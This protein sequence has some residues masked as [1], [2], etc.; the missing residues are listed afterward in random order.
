MTIKQLLIKKWN[1][2]I[3]RDI[4]FRKGLNLIINEDKEDRWNNVGK[5]TV[6]R[7]I[8]YCL[9]SDGTS[10]YEDKEQKS[11]NMVVWS[12][13]S[14]NDVC[15]ELHTEWR[16]NEQFV[17]KR[18]FWNNS[19]SCIINDEVFTLTEYREQLNNIFFSN[20]SW[21]PTFRML[22]HKFIRDTDH[23]M[24]NILRFWD[25]STAD[26]E[27]ERI[28]LFL[29][30]FSDL[31][32]L[33]GK[34]SCVNDIKKLDDK[35]K[36]F[37]Q[38]TGIKSDSEL[39]Q[40][41]AIYDNKINQLTELIDKSQVYD[42]IE[43]II[44]ELK[45]ISNRAS[46]LRQNI[47]ALEIDISLNQ[48]SKTKLIKELKTIDVNYIKSIYEQAEIF[49]PKIDKTF[50]EVIEFHEKTVKNRLNLIENSID[51]HYKKLEVFKPEYHTLLTKQQELY[52]VVN[53]KDYNTE[54]DV[55]KEKLNILNQEKWWLKNNLEIFQ[56]L[57]RNLEDLKKR[58]DTIIK[59]YKESLLSVE[60]NLSIFNSY[61][62]ERSE[63]IYGIPLIVF[64]EENNSV[65]KFKTKNSL[66]ND[67]TWEKKSQIAVF[68]FAYSKF[69]DEIDAI[70]PRFILH[71]N[72]EWKDPHHLKAIF[73]LANVFGGQYIVPVLKD[74]L[75]T[76]LSDE[77][78]EKFKV[79]SLSVNDKFFR[80]ETPS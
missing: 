17:F 45:D 9:W 25:S 41:I 53:N 66:G 52:K 6:L 55:L 58:Y 15:F 19:S 2:T 16:K 24:A 26:K 75:K 40:S 18:F 78:I 12:F 72:I 80:I 3:I 50:E 62:S 44:L 34:I 67:W 30:G 42:G 60:T 74:K 1:W 38:T 63:S 43:K 68:D 65:I 49:L 36:V 73:N 23:T 7:C 10:L 46:I 61:F 27:Y 69:L 11:N 79:I 59:I 71:D 33:N 14:D 8:D 76:V 28:H 47:S 35:I 56:S 70:W 64:L 39:K 51:Q 29:F 13:L 20:N 77:E 48:K 37:R 57:F 54:L 31:E 4:S 21:K 5:T 32:T 22:I